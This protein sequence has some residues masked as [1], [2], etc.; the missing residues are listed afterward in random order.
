MGAEIQNRGKQSDFT[1]SKELTPLKNFKTKGAVAVTVLVL[2]GLAGVALASNDGR[3]N[4][5]PSIEPQRQTA[6]RPGVSAPAAAGDDEGRES[7]ALAPEHTGS[8]PVVTS[9]SGGAGNDDGEYSGDRSDDEHDSD[10]HGSAG[11]YDDDDD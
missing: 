7:P 5:S 3:P 1:T 10:D 6:D 4:R 8:S 9:S 11:E 2:A